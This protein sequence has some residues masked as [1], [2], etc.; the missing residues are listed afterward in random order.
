LFRS[1]NHGGPAGARG[2]APRQAAA[3]GRSLQEGRAEDP[4]SL[5]AALRERFRGAGARDQV[6]NAA[7]L[8]LRSRAFVARDA[9]AGVGRDRMSQSSRRKL[10]YAASSTSR[11][12]GFPKLTR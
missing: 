12:P 10:L 9:A 3:R 1:H 4:A 8:L 5:T 6:G 2:I 7:S 11:I